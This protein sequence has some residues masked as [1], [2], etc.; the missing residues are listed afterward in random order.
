MTQS[1]ARISSLPLFEA[2]STPRLKAGCEALWRRLL[3]GENLSDGELLELILPGGASNP[4]RLLH[5]FGDLGRLVAAPAARL[6][7]LP[8]VSDDA[9]RALKL[10]EAIALRLAHAKLLE[11]PVLS[12]WAALLR[13]CRTRLAHHSREQFHVLFLDNRNGLI[14]EE[15]LG[16]GTVDH[17]PV[18]PREVM[19]RALELD[20]SALILLHNHPS[21]NPEPSPADHDM[22]DKL[23]SAANA[24][25]I[26][27][28][29]H[30]IIGAGSEVSFASEGWL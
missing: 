2:A 7:R 30:L 27:L 19:K 22:T 21:G 26:A 11:R 4:A 25:G 15:M 24:L 16:Q 6:A 5:E 13:Y 28:H 9:V 23:K 3:A 1:L 10:G 12:N 20:A 14:A 29:D 8:R 18:Y 17:V